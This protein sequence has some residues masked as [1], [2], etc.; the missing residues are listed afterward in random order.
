MII[1]VNDAGAGFRNVVLHEAFYISLDYWERSSSLNMAQMA[2]DESGSFTYV[3]AHRDPG[4]HNWLDT[5]GLRRSIIGHRWQAFPGGVAS[6]RP[7]FSSR[8]VRL[9]NLE[10]TLPPGVRRI[11][12]AGREAQLAARRAGF[13]R[14]FIDR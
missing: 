8:V 13:Q 1:T 10:K 11:D 5:C 3:V 2:A 14:R 9:E 12:A 4:V 7:Q 6:T